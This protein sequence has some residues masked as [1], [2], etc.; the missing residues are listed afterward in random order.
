MGSLSY[1]LLKKKQGKTNPLVCLPCW[2]LY[3]SIICLDWQ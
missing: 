2:Y 3:F 1:F